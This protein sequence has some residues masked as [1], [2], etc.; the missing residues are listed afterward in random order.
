MY[1]SKGSQQKENPEYWILYIGVTGQHQTPGQFVRLQ[2]SQ[3]LDV[4]IKVRSRR[5]KRERQH[6]P[7]LQCPCPLMMT[8]D[9]RLIQPSDV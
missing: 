4:P 5:C 2:N 9:T 7:L 1:T 8:N 6:S 3:S